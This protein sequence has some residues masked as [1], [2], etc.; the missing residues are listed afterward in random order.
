MV[1]TNDA[2]FEAQHETSALALAGLASAAGRAKDLLLLIKVL[3]RIGLS[4]P[5][6]SRPRDVETENNLDKL[7]PTSLALYNEQQT[8]MGATSRAIS[9]VTHGYSLPTKVIRQV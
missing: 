5:S 6:L 2:A 1:F 8:L 7:S 9:S 3:L 4:R